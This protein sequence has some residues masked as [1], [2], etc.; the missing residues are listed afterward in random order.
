MSAIPA[1]LAGFGDGAHPAVVNSRVRE[2]ALLGASVVVPLALALGLSIAV[3]NPNLG[4]TLALMV[5]AI[6]VIALMVSPRYEVTVTVVMLYLGLLDGPVKLGIGGHETVSAVRDV[7]IG[8]VCVGAILRLLVNRQRLLLPTMSLW[9]LAYVAVV[10]G[11][12]FNPHTDG[13]LKSLG[14]FRQLLEWVPFFF[15]GYGLVR[16]KQRLRRL[17][18]VLGVIALANGVTSAYQSRLSPQQLASWGPGYMELALGAKG[19]G[20]RTFKS[21]GVAHVRP[22]GLGS[23]AGFAGGMGVIALPA[24]LALL[25]SGRRRRRWALMLLCLGALVAVATGLGRLQLIGAVVAVASFAGLS[26]AGG[27][28][29]ARRLVTLVSVVILAIPVG[30]ALVSVVGSGEFSRYESIATGE[31]NDNKLPGLTRIPN[32]LSKAPF[33]VGL[34]VAGAASGFGGKATGASTALETRTADAETQY[35]FLADEVGLLGL[36][37]W[38]GLTIRLLTLA[39]PAVRRIRDTE[40]LLGLAALTGSFIAITVMGIY[41]PT[42]TSAALGAYFW[43][44]AGVATYWFAGPGRAYQE[45]GMRARAGGPELA[46]VGST[47]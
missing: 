26:L 12:A 21:E 45:G 17:F 8:A 32:Q 2:L 7:L 33:G 39:I 15:F 5:G 4:L 44:F 38:V 37:V 36:L 42:L 24:T 13:I 9:V 6:G 1:R 41:G 3:P 10:F 47:P 35:N 30:A 28:R 18:L 23:D 11:E 20:G 14:G 46:G 34:G 16:T 40:L 25:A 31:H 22:P 19:L 27:G 43:G 29:V